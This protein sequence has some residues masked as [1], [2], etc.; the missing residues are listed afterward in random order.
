PEFTMLEF[1]TAHEDYHFAAEFTEKL[2]QKAVFESCQDP[3]VLFGEHKLDFSKSFRRL[4]MKQSVMEYGNYQEDDLSE[5]N[6]DAALKNHDIKIEKGK[7]SWGHKLLA[8]FEELVEHKLIQPTFITDFPIEVSPLAK[9]DPQNPNIA[10]RWELFV[11]GMELANAFNELN[12]PH[13]Q[14]DRF[15]A[16][17]EAHASGDVEA[18]HYDADY[19]QALE[20]GL[21]P[22][23]GVGIGIDRFV[24]LLTN[25]TSIK[26]VILFPTL[27]KKLI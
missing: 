6:I 25:T 17:A 8:L 2:L 5:K 12:D 1:Y 19:I 24:M 16:Q 26:D 14:A 11:A 4:S 13:D 22:A 9:R 23:V 27:K 21:P 10:S 18:H 15:K 7:T 3:I 20:Y